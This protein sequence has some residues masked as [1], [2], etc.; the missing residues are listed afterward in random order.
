MSTPGH[1]FSYFLCLCVFPSFRPRRLTAFALL[2][3]VIRSFLVSEN[4]PHSIPT[5]SQEA[6]TKSL[7]LLVNWLRDR[8]GLLV[9]GRERGAATHN[10][11][12]G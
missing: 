11:G 4:L 2:T 3:W 6:E 8:P 10:S 9:S 1:D 5:M 7:P 12:G